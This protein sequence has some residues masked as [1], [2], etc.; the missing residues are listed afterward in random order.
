[1][2]SSLDLKHLDQLNVCSLFNVTCH[3]SG[4]CLISDLP[5][6]SEVKLNSRGNVLQCGGE[7][8]LKGGEETGNFQPF[9]LQYKL[10]FP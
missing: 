1:M 7:N 5:D 4:F 8:E 2:F 9:F 6:L 3:T 10:C